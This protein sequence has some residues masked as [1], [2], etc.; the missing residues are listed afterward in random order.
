MRLVVRTTGEPMAM[1]HAI[2]QAVWA[3]D[4]NQVLFNA[5]SMDDVLND[6]VAEPR[7]RMIVSTLVA[8]IA[9]MMALTGLF[10]LV[11]YRVIQRTTEFGLRMALGAQPGDVL[12]L[13][14]RHTLTLVCIGLGGGVLGALT[15]SRTLGS[16]MHDLLYGASARDAATY[17]AVAA[18][19]V[20]TALLASALPAR[21]ATRIDP[22]SALR[23]E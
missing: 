4:P 13:V 6:A 2:E 20:A 21:R 8:G 9:V 3:I 11:S 7:Q 19:F 10:G 15:I 16:I 22:A 14:L 23:D 12:A 17:A 1:T 5:E 18:V